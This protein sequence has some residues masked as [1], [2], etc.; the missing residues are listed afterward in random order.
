[1]VCRQ[2]AMAAPHFRT[3]EHRFGS[4]AHGRA[5]AAHPRH[6]RTDCNGR[7]QE[8]EKEATGRGQ[9]HLPQENGCHSPV[10]R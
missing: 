3:G 6:G 7:A 2:P 10:R 5:Y 8:S 4:P 1:M 9:A